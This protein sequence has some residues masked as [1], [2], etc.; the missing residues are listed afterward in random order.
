MLRNKDD[1]KEP[2]V[3]D[4]VKRFDEHYK[5]RPRPNCPTCKNNQNVIPAVY[6]I[7]TP[8]LGIYAQEGHVRLYGCGIFPGQKIAKGFCKKCE[9]DVYADDDESAATSTE[10]ASSSSKSTNNADN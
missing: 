8:E 10:A 1:N 3:A 7:P 5:S 2:D 9:K 6:G 4:I